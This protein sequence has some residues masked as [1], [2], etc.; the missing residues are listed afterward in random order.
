MKTL[1]TLIKL[2]KSRVDEQRQHVAKLQLM[3][4]AIVQKITALEIEKA[5]EQVA[6]ENNPGARST[7]GAFSASYGGER[8]GA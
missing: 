6:A 1:T 2:Q 4:D 3:L 8:A 5:R 7:Y